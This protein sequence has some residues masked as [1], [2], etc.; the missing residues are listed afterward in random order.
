MQ[1]WG[2]VLLLT[3]IL[4]GGGY[5]YFNWTQNTIEDLTQEKATLTEEI[6]SLE[7]AV[8]TS[9]ITINQLREQAVF[10][11]GINQKLQQERQA[12]TEYQGRLLKVLRSH[13]LTALAKAKPGLI[14]NRIN[15]GTQTVF[16]NLESI[17]RD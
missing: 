1:A 3:A 2:L 4:A 9:E 13:D 8:E 5:L 12:A 14:E 7:K 11:A 15:E 6:V 16:D 17:S 10:Q